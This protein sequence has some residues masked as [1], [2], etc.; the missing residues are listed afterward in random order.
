MLKKGF[1]L[2]E[3]LITLTIVGVVAA[4][5]IPSVLNHYKKTEVSSK[6]KKFY[7]EMTQAIIL[8]ELDNGPSEQWQE[9]SGTRDDDGVLLGSVN[10]EAALEYFEKYLAPYL[11]YTKIDE[12]DLDNMG[13]SRYAVCYLDNGTLIYITFAN[14]VDFIADINGLD[15]PNETGRDRF[16][17]LICPERYRSTYCIENQKLCTY[18]SNPSKVSSRSQILNYCAK[19]SPLFCSWLIYTDSWEIKNDYPYKI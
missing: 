3:A 10:R 7:S 1:T 16:D 14:C 13:D 12:A 18:G 6:L 8:S 9:T 4:M 17:F 19:S 15:S 2:A 5:T 11:R